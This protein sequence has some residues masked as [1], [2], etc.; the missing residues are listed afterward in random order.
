MNKLYIT[1]VVLFMVFSCS[2]PDT[3]AFEETELQFADQRWELVRMS[4]SMANSTTTGADM[5]WQEYYVFCPDGRFQKE[6]ERAGV[7]S[8]AAGTFEV[9]EYENDDADYLEL[10]Y[11]EGYGLIGN[12][13]GDQKEVL[14]YRS[15]TEISNTWMACDGPGL[16]YVL[17]AD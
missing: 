16:D 12:C 1:I 8:K 3:S 2:V 4:G 5:E 13:F 15:A 10:S 17:V 11:T 9:V 7:V 6:R 14:I